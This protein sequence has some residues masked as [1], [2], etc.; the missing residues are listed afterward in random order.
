MQP[1][2]VGAGAS[3]CILGGVDKGERMPPGW[4]GAG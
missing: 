2:V 3:E 1:E 4:V